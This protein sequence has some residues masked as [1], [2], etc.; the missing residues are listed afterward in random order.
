MNF[1][2]EYD[3]NRSIQY[4]HNPPRPWFADKN[5]KKA[6]N[7]HKESTEQVAARQ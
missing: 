7:E 3:G 1:G 4:D 6:P 5:Y 2:R